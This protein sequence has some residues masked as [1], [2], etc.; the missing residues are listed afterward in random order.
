[1]EALPIIVLFIAGLFALGLAAMQFG[2]DTRDA[3][4]DDRRR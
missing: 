4:V 3:F 2:V 1:M